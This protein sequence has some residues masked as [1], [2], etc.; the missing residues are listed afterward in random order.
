MTIICVE[1]ASDEMG[2]DITGVPGV[3]VHL[4]EA[5]L[6]IFLAVYLGY[7]LVYTLITDKKMRRGV[8]FIL[9]YSLLLIELLIKVIY[10]PGGMKP[11]CYEPVIYA[12]FSDYPSLAQSLSIL[13]VTCQ[14]CDTSSL[15]QEEK[16]ARF[17]CLKWSVLCFA[18]GYFALFT[19]VHETAI[20]AESSMAPYYV[21]ALAGQVVILTLFDL[22]LFNLL[23][24]LRELYQTLAIGLSTKKVVAFSVLLGIRILISVLNVSGVL[25]LLRKQ[26]MLFIVELCFNLACEVAPILI[27]LSLLAFQTQ[28]KATAKPATKVDIA[29]LLQSKRISSASASDRAQQDGESAARISIED[30]S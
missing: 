4:V 6:Y 1:N 30:D 22:V 27:L 12:F 21:V 5:A 8:F 11:F 3:I 24:Q 17:V 7:Q 13:M 18:G 19:I 23:K 2:Y 28:T 29:A 15:V 25:Q 26:G 20:R 9:F 16:K 14:Y 10:F